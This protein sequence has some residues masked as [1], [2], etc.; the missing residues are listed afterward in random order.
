MKVSGQWFVGP[1]EYGVTG[2]QVAFFWPSR[3]PARSEDAEQRAPEFRASRVGQGS[4]FSEVAIKIFFR[5][6]Q[7]LGPAP[8]GLSRLEK[9]EVEGRVLS[10]TTVRK[11]LERW[12]VR[13]PVFD[14]AAWYVSTELQLP[15]GKPAILFCDKYPPVSIAA[16]TTGFL[17][18]P[19]IVVEMRFATKHAADWPEIF[20]ETVR[21]LQLLRK[22]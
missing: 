14:V 1:A 22:V 19:D 6:R 10:K 13:D 3:T 5:S 11:G 21:V 7:A 8:V 9:A 16:C 12:L 2:N 4:N 20:L 15:N 17:W 18:H